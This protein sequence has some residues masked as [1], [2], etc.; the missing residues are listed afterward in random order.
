MVRGETPDGASRQSLGD[1]IA[2]AL[3][4]VSQLLRHEINLAKSEL[5]M[6]VRRI[7]VAAALF[8]FGAFVA[9]LLMVLLC[10]AYAYGLYALGVPGGLWGAFLWVALTCFLLALLVC[11]I[12]VLGVRRVTGMRMTRETVIDDISM[13]RRGSADASKSVQPGEAPAEIPARPLPR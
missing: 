6:D 4:D 5:R 9:C 3:K 7:A 11:G 10:F 8:G 1:L 12:A 2:L 13:L